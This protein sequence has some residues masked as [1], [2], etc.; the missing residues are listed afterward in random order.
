VALEVA[1]NRGAKE[2]M[3]QRASLGKGAMAGA[4]GF[5]L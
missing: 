4:S 3:E 1:G 2:G 5:I